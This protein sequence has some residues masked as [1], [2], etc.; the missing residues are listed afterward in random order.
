MELEE[1]VADFASW[2]QLYHRG[3]ASRDR[4]MQRYR[5]TQK[6]LYYLTGAMQAHALYLLDPDGWLALSAEIAASPTPDEG[7]LT[8]Q[9]RR[10]LEAACGQAS[11]PT[12]DAPGRHGGG[13]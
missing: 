11:F 2:V 6:E 3:V 9:L 10:E 1:G 4:L 5:A 12:L 13:A 8:T 7:S